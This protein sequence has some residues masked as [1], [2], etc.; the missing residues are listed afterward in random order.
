LA[1]LPL[2]SGKEAIKAFMKAGWV[3]VHQKG[4]HVV[5]KKKGMRKVLTIPLHSELGRGLLRRQIADAGLTV[6]QFCELI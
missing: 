2:I 5:L 6:E 3:P 1:E 4:S